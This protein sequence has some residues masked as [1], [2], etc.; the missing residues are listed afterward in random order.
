M[1]PG[2]ERNTVLLTHKRGATIV[3]L[4]MGSN[5]EHFSHAMELV[6]STSFTMV[7]INTI[8]LKVLEAI[9]EAGPDA[10]LTAHEIVSRLLIQNQDA[11]DMLDRM[12]R[13]LA[14]YS[15]VTCTKGIHESKP[16][17][18]YGLTPVATY[19]IPNKQGASLGAL[20]EFVEDKV[21]LNAW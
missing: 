11:P 2:M 10:R 7:L 16:V 9:A 21:Y 6:T 5:E 18:L 13:L 12:L 14:S 20:M 19:L 15:I 17:R 4:K 1:K 8:K 3:V